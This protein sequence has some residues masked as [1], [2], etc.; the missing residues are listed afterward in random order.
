MKRDGYEVAKMTGKWSD[1]LFL[2]LKD[3]TKSTL[4]DPTKAKVAK[5]VVPT[6]D[7]QEEFESRRLWAP[8][9]AAIL[10]RDQTLATTEKSKIE[11]H[12][13]KLRQERTDGKTSEFVPRFFKLAEN[14]IDWDCLLEEYDVFFRRGGCLTHPHSANRKG[15]TNDHFMKKLFGSGASA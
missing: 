12:Q 5:K 9:T 3:G 13:R 10:A 11:D 14:E 2:T 7:Q 1:E 8:V 15:M 6:E 4:F